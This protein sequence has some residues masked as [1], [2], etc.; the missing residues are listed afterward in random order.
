MTRQNVLNE[1]ILYIIINS[2]HLYA[3]VVVLESPSPTVAQKRQNTIDK[4]L[5]GTKQE[6]QEWKRQEESWNEHL[7]K[8]AECKDTVIK[9]QYDE[10][11]EGI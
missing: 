6:L 5:E 11:N 7:R 4:I 2:S 9:F 8:L 10:A 1:C 3:N